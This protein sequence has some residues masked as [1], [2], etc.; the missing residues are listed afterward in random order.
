MAR[1]LAS[2]ARSR[3]AEGEAQIGLELIRKSIKL[4]HAAIRK[5]D[6]YENKIKRYGM[7]MRAAVPGTREFLRICHS[8]IVIFIVLECSP[9]GSVLI[10]KLEL[11]LALAKER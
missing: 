2:S 5:R 3:L 10:D 11:L 1:K 4:S 9:R 8:G 6:Q 7:R